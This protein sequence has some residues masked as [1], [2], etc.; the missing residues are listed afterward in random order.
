[1]SSLWRLYSLNAF[2]THNKV[3]CELRW[4]IGIGIGVYMGSL[5][6]LLKLCELNDISE[7]NEV[8]RLDVFNYPV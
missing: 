7:D 1:M 8:S 6:G 3:V 2:Q 5:S 4:G